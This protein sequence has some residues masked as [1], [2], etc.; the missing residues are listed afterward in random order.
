MLLRTSSSPGIKGAIF[1]VLSESPVR[2]FRN[3]ASNSDSNS[4]S[5]GRHHHHHKN[6]PSSHLSFPPFSPTSSSS[7]SGKS[8]PSGPNR[9][10][11]KG[12]VGFRRALSD[13]NIDRFAAASFPSC[14]SSLQQHSLTPRRYPPRKRM[15]HSA[16]SFSV[17]TTTDEEVGEEE[18]KDGVLMRTVTIGESIES[19][20]FSFGKGK[21]NDMG[22]IEE[23]EEKETG[24]DED[25]GDDDGDQSKNLTFNK[26]V[27]IPPSLSFVEDENQPASPPMYLATGLGFDSAIDFQAASSLLDEGGDL[28]E[29]YSKMLDQ[30]PSHPLFLRNYAHLLQSKG[31][32]HGAEEY[33]HRA[34]QVEP[35]DG[36]IL[37]QYAKL[38]WE[39]HRD[40][41]RAMVCFERAAQAAPQDSN[42]LGAYASFL[43]EIDE[44]E[45]DEGKRE[46]KE[47]VPVP[48]SAFSANNGEPSSKGG[49][50]V[51]DHYRQMVEEHPNNAL[52]L[53][54]YAQFL[55]QTKGDM[56]GAEEYYSRAILAD[57]GD[58]EIMSRY[59]KLVWE[60]HRDQQKASS[61]FERAVQAAPSD[62]HVLAAYASFLWE[63]EEDE[64]VTEPGGQLPESAQLEGAIVAAAN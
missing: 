13:S 11:G 34:I 3:P 61:Y 17:F 30:F 40:Q 6:A 22:L 43:W 49:L 14:E 26:R 52:V 58:G 20:D 57:P 48:L 9:E 31:D 55:Y 21:E 15:L 25:D 39:L 4:N 8:S 2:D 63:S 60:L 7:S 32:L 51:E 54:N 56:Q 18:Q 27:V 42:V 59:A 47:H 45:G 10:A 36:E 62:S 24:E 12:G 16:P 46:Q 19:G 28:E 53:R 50:I 35:G 37:M 38:V 1:T 33:Y 41:D 64:L 23:V 5:S 29:Y 44:E